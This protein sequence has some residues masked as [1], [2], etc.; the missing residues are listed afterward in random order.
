MDWLKKKKKCFGYASLGEHKYIVYKKVH[1][2]RSRYYEMKYSRM[3]HILL[4][5]QIKHPWNTDSHNITLKCIIFVKG[6]ESLF[7]QPREKTRGGKGR[8]NWEKGVSGNWHLVSSSS[9]DEVIEPSQR[10]ERFWPQRAP[11]VC[12]VWISHECTSTAAIMRM[13]RRSVLLCNEPHSK[14]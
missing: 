3:W 8:G 2:D 9:Y 7:E 13:N 5:A 10:S 4:G 6:F 1:L 14:G 11:A 12:S